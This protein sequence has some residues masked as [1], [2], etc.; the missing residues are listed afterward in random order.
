MIIGVIDY[1]MGNIRSLV[2]GLMH[3]GYKTKIVS[4]S[5]EFNSVDIVI[6][7]GVGA[8]PNAMN[9][10]KDLNL[11][12]AI[13]DLANSGEKKIIGI[14]LGMQ[15]L[16]SQSHEFKKTKGLDLIEGDVVDF[17]SKIDLKIPHMGWN[18]IYT[19]HNE[20]IHYQED[21]YFVHSFYCLPK[22]ESD[23]LFSSSY[24]I[25]FCAGVKKGNNLFGLQFHP[26]KS[27]KIGLELLDFI[28]KY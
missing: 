18:N 25:E 24:G 20:F 11:E 3:L 4:A 27:Q 14:C 9:K 26:E 23:V 7:P 15:L 12:S 28:I 21:F 19:S 17:R 16:F 10:L 22:N 6:L 8:F 13:I 2:N 1:G 5:N